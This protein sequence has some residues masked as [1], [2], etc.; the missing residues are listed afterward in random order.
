[1]TADAARMPEA[2]ISYPWAEPPAFGRPLVVA[3][4]VE[5]LRL[6]LPMALDHVNCWIL[7]EGSGVTIVDTGFDSART[8]SLWT[9][10][11]AGRTVRR[12]V[13]TH[14]H[15]DHIGLAGWFQSAHGAQ[16]MTSRTAWLMARMLQLDEQERPPPETVA[17]WRAAGM[18]AE[19]LAE[20][21]AQRPFNFADVVA[22]LPLGYTRLA[23]AQMVRLGGRWWHVRMGAGHA[24]EHVTLWEEG[25]D[26]VLG[27]DQLLPSISPNLGV[28]AT[29]PE[30]DPVADWLV[31]C[32]RLQGWATPDK[33]V[34]PGHKAPFRGL[35]TRLSQLIANHVGA[36]DRLEAHLAR[37]RTA[38]QCFQPLFR[39]TI[40]KGEYG[41]ALVEALAHCLHLEHL[42]RARRRLGAEG[43]WIFESGPAA[44]H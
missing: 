40:G 32:K 10:A 4:G 17:F 25:G 15:P 16:L 38:A 11:L 7:D 24:P 37:P 28:Y 3:E 44:R 31:A 19:I 41:L 1:M 8:R 30:A 18:D 42:G 20:R 14:H 36:L 35:P 12:V 22:P 27:G 29:E 6:P 5:W 23:E 26:L 43:A 39:R 34:L 9:E 21:V 2:T 13:A 33:L